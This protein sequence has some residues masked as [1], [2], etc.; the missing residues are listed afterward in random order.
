MLL[1]GCAGP[2]TITVKGDQHIGR[3]AQ[4]QEV[5]RWG[6]AILPDGTGL[7]QGQGSALEGAPLYAAKCAQCHGERG[8]GRDALGPQLVGGIGT[9][10][11]KS[12]VL[13]VGS[14]WPYST[15]VWDFIH[16]AMPYTNPGSL[17]PSETYALTAYILYRNG[18]ISRTATMDRTSLPK[19]QMPNR[20]GFFP[21]PRPDAAANVN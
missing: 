19:V 2:R 15:S 11:S 18:I 20:S 4:R 10:H 3:P 21:D 12:P 17:S 16:K 8:E 5:E 7:P 9:L 14:Y 1:I 13:T 6:S